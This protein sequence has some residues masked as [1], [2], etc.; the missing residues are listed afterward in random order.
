MIYDY[1]FFKSFQLSKK[2][3]QWKDTPVLFSIMITLACMILNAFTLIIALEIFGVIDEIP[4]VS[5][6]RYLVGFF[7]V[8]LP[9]VYYTKRSTR[10]ISKYE[11]KENSSGKTYNSVVVIVLY[12][13]FSILLINLVSVYR[14]GWD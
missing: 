6:Y 7:L 9:C 3:K 13:I 11:K 14:F 4:S 2:L 1:L 8:A 5:K 10:I 12:Y